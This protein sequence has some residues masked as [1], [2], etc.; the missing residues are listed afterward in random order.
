[1][2][3]LRLKVRTFLVSPLTSYEFPINEV[4][5]I[6][7]CNAYSLNEKKGCLQGGQKSKAGFHAGTKNQVV[8]A[9]S[10][11]R[12]PQVYRADI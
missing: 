1:M 9:L 12:I 6:G 8:G 3:K 4:T 7:R 2:L 5:A 11:R 10:S